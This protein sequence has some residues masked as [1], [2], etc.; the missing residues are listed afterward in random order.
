M[1]ATLREPANHQALGIQEIFA[2]QSLTNKF[3]DPL[4]DPRTPDIVLKVNTGVIFTGGSND[5][6]A[7]RAE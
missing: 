6:R 2:G 4:K 7:W 1:V 3:N 5:R